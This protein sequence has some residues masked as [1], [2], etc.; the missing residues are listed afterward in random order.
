[1]VST[2]RS[3]LTIAT[4]IRE[5]LLRE[6]GHAIEV[7]QLLG[8]ARYARDVLLV[9]DACVG[10]EL[11]RLA[12]EFRQLAPDGRLPQPQAD[13]GHCAQPNDWARDTS[14]FGVTQ[15][16]DAAAVA[17]AGGKPGSGWRSRLPWR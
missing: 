15:P 4:R 14:G 17:P 8:R 2:N 5:L 13:G 10:T 12:A 11:P 1:M 3:R 7:D 9:C 6:L 16:P